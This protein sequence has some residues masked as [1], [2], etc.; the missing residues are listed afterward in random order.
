MCIKL[1]KTNTPFAS[2]RAL[3]LGHK[4]QRINVIQYL[5]STCMRTFHSIKKYI[6]IPYFF[7]ANNN[8]LAGKHVDGI[9]RT[10]L[11]RGT[12]IVSMSDVQTIAVDVN[13]ITIVFAEKK[14]RAAHMFVPTVRSLCL[15][16]VE[17]QREKGKN[18][19]RTV[20]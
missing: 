14:A 10:L 9:V 17:L 11:G 8:I 5:I 6:K 12:D 16:M 20:T 1:V 3:S 4:R 13:S 15:I 18:G 19:K 2:Q 7:E